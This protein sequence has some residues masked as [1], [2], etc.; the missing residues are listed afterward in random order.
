MKEISF[1]NDVLPLKNKLFRLALR[2]TLNREEA[3]DVV[4]DTLIKVWNARDRWQELDSIEAYSLTIARNLSLDRIK[5]LLAKL[6]HPERRLPPVIHIAGTNGKGSTT[7]YL[8]AMI[9]S[10]GKRCHVYTS[11]HLV[12]FAERIA[13]PGSDGVA[14][15][16]DEPALDTRLVAFR[17]S[18]GNSVV[19]K[20][21]ALARLMRSLRAGRAVAMLIDQNVKEGDGIFVDFLGRPAATTT[22]AAAL[23][24]K[25]GCALLPCRTVLGRGRYRIAY[26]APLFADPEAPRVVETERLTR[27]LTGR[28]EAWVR[29][30]PEQWLWIHKRWKTRPPEER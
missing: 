24:L 1:Q 3:E 30:V 10:S 27:A 20:R 19:Y 28:I 7:A 6:G 13:L 15:P 29:E 21:H 9:E 23:A 18:F 8:K 12:R 11:P 2:I 17:T 16:I 26:E 5:G 22:V 4:Q 25:T 14:R